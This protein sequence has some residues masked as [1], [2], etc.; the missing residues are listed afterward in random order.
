MCGW[1]CSGRVSRDSDNNIDIV[2]PSVS[3]V[4]LVAVIDR[5]QIEIVV[6]GERGCELLFVCGERAPEEG[7][8]LCFNQGAAAVAIGL[9]ASTFNGL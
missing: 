3:P 6:S 5:Y 8:V 2:R 4:L 1:H 9:M 7:H